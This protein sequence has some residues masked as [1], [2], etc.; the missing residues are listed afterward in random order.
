MFSTIQELH[1]RM[2]RYLYLCGITQARYDKI[3]LH[4]EN[5]PLER[6]ERVLTFLKEVEIPW[7]EYKRIREL[8]HITEDMWHMYTVMRF[9]GLIEVQLLRDQKNKIKELFTKWRLSNVKAKTDHS[10]QHPKQSTTEPVQS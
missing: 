3:I 1:E 4:L 2:R 5:A 7:A 9:P 10:K 8:P 6:Q